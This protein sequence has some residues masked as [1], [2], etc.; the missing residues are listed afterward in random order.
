MEW[1]IQRR[2]AKLSHGAYGLLQFG[3]LSVSKQPRAVFTPKTFGGKESSRSYKKKIY[4]KS[5][6]YVYPVNNV[7]T[8][9]SFDVFTIIHRNKYYGKLLF[10]VMNLRAPNFF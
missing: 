3:G 1:A 4:L 10:V 5:K 9:E 6:V 8:V 7:F 2:F